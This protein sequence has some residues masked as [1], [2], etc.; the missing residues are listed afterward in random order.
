MNNIFIK[1]IMM[2]FLRFSAA[3]LVFIGAA[4]TVNAGPQIQAGDSNG[5]SP[6]INQ[7][8]YAVDV[9]LMGDDRVD[10]TIQFTVQADGRPMSMQFGTQIDY[11]SAIT[12]PVDSDGIVHEGATS[13]KIVVGDT[14]V[15]SLKEQ[16]PPIPGYLI[17]DFDANSSKLLSMKKIQIGD[18][19]IE[20]PEIDVADI[21]STINVTLNDEVTISDGDY[22]KRKNITIKVR[23]ME[24][25]QR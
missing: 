12:T 17:L 23:K 19:A 25:A 5:S 24:V 14:V 22:G 7:D 15:I 21:S 11:L 6:Y 2:H 1:K 3:I 18:H 9:V 8:K 10:H 16:A 4:S 20:T 13:Q